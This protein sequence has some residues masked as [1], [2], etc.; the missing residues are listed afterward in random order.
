MIKL[1]PFLLGHTD[2][3]GREDGEYIG[4]QTSYQ[5][6]QTVHEDTEE[7]GDDRHARVN[8]DALCRCDKD[9]AG[10]GQDDGMSR[11]DVGEETDH[12]GDRLGENAEELHERHD[13][14]RYFQIDRRMGPENLLPIMLRG[15]C[16]RRD[17]RA[18]R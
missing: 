2:K 1:F 17:E 3:V 10:K 7:H 18:D 16:V 15:E 14:K 6:L 11:H 9:Q 8:Q 5:D 4:L 13:G 12:Q